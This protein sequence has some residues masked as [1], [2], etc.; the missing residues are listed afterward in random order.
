MWESHNVSFQ[1]M[2]N[3]QQHCTS[4]NLVLCNC[5]LRYNT[6]F[7]IKVQPYIHKQCSKLVG[8]NQTNLLYRRL[9]RLMSNKY[10]KCITYKIKGKGKWELLPKIEEITVDRHTNGNKIKIF[11]RTRP[12]FSIR[13]ERMYVSTR[14]RWHH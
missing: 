1:I 6:G 10:I 9:C 12:S 13:R 5:K 4:I 8:Y 7:K 11:W 3:F 14:Q 2:V